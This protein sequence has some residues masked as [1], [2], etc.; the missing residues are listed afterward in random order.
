MECVTQEEVSPNLGE[1]YQH[2]EPV[3]LR[4]LTSCPPSRELAEWVETHVPTG[5]VFAMNRWSLFQP[6]MY[7]PQQVVALSGSEFSLP[8]EDLL[9][10]G[11]AQAYRESMRDRGVQPFF[12]DQETADQRGT[13]IRELGITHVLVDP[14]YYDSMRRV[15]DGLPQLVSLRYA[16]GRWAVYEVRRDM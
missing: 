11:Y 2:G 12:N 9:N 6:T 5:A 13:F 15:L 7:L 8:M 14:M 3:T 1:T 16:D 4:G 10:P